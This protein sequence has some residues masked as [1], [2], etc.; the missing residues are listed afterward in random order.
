MNSSKSMDAFCY[1]ILNNIDFNVLKSLSSEQLSAIE[2]A[3][4]ACQL[5]TK[6]AIDIRKT[7]K[8]YFINFYFV[9]LVGRDRRL[10]VQE[11]EED[12]REKV[13]L[14]GNILYAMIVFSGLLLFVIV[15]LYGLKTMIGIDLF[16]GEHMG[17]I[18]GL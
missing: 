13:T 2:D 12:R 18:F 6:H 11:I 1:Y 3:I 10:S 16:P 17:R 4:K 8:L 14:L 5:R 15:S 7:I 9:F